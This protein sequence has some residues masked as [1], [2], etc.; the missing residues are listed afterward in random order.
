MMMDIKLED[1]FETFELG[2]SRSLFECDFYD[3]HYRYFDEIDDDYLSA[4]NLSAK[5]LILSYDM[6]YPDFYIKIGVE[7]AESRSRPHENITTWKDVSYEYLYYFGDS[8]SY[9]DSKGFK[10]FLSAAIYIFLKI[11]EKNNSFMDS[12]IYR[13]ELQWEKDNHVFN[14]AQ[15]KFIRSFFIEHYKRDLSWI[16]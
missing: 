10:F 2:D 14:T 15:K 3:T 12:F 13:F 7:A 16:I 5:D 6:G 1:I 8:C 4:V 9:L 11:P